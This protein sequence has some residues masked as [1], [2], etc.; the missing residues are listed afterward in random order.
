C[1]AWLTPQTHPDGGNGCTRDYNQRLSPKTV[2]EAEETSE[3]S[4][5]GVKAQKIHRFFTA[6]HLGGW[7]S[8]DSGWERLNLGPEH[9]VSL[10]QGHQVNRFVIRTPSLPAMKQ[11]ANPFKG[12]PAHGGMMP[13]A[14]PP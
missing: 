5:Q 13:L 6:R 8:A 14:A 1:P 12:Q 7:L 2:A 9:R 11:N 3:V 4:C 10:L